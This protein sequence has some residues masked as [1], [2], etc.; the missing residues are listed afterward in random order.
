MKPPR[1]VILLA[2]APIGAMISAASAYGDSN[3]QRSDVVGHAYVNDNTAD[4]NTV[5]GFDRH[6]DGSL[7]P[8]PGSP[9]T[10]GGAGLGKGLASQG[11][12]QL[13]SDGSY[14]LAVDAGSN[15]ISV[16]RLG[17]RGVPQLVG[18]PVFSGGS[19]PVS[20]AVSG[21]LVYVANAGVEE[22]NITGF[23][24]APDGVLYPLA[25][26]TV[27]LGWRRPGPAAARERY[28]CW[29]GCADLFIIRSIGKPPLRTKRQ[30][31]TAATQRNTMLRTVV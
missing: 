12:I 19:E 21:D 3:H 18:P 23:R 2:L 22:T 7:T 29:T 26:S 30:T 24:L 8:I 27:A 13:S 16:L 25:G 5:A 17:A 14:L 1:L 15:Q 6:S 28:V 10:I 9:F 11:A 4:S 31:S 20:I